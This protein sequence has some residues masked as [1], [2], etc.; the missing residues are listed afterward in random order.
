[1][2]T[3]YNNHDNKPYRP[4]IVYLSE[5]KTKRSRFVN[6]TR[7]TRVNAEKEPIVIWKK[8]RVEYNVAGACGH[9]N[10]MHRLAL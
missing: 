1:M 8:V 4:P 10:H 7:M 5:K 2:K 9:R 6:P 3:V